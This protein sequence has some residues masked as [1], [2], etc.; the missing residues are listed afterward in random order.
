MD[1]VKR[2]NLTPHVEGGAFRELYRDGER[3]KERPA[4]GVIYYEL[5]PPWNCGKSTTPS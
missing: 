2:F 3:A 1:F 5:G 4:H